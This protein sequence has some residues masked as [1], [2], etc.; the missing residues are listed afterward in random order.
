MK[1]RDDYGDVLA[2]NEVRGVWKVVQ[3]RTS[4]TVANFWKLIGKRR[5]AIDR[6]GKL[7]RES[8]PQSFVFAG[9]PCFGLFQIGSAR[10]RTTT[11]II[12][13]RACFSED[14]P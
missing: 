8:K 5:N 9:V 3:Q 10:C 7:L 14:Q 6:H 4:Y 13:R 11:G 2:T 1:N 12:P